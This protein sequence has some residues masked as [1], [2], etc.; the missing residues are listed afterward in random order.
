MS[1]K[2]LFA[3]NAARAPEKQPSE[4]HVAEKHRCRYTNNRGERCQHRLFDTFSGLCL[5]HQRYMREEAEEQA[6]EL[7]SQLFADLSA[8]NNRVELRSF[9]FR[10][11]RL[12]SQ[13]QID[14]HDAQMLVYS[15]NLLLQTFPVRK[16]K[17]PEEERKVEI[18]WDIL[19]KKG[20]QSS[21]TD[22][23]GENR[24]GSSEGHANPGNSNDVCKHPATGVR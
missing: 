2:D 16:P 4:K 19:D 3:K 10:L 5:L 9:L 6:H 1:L 7:T 11:M 23:A 8:M 18:I 17:P 20:P 21:A 22:A 12:I 14:R 13:R 24:Q 15:C